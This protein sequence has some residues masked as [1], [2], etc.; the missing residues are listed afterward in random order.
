[1]TL[2]V[3]LINRDQAVQVSDRRL[4]YTD[5]REPDE[6]SDKAI[7]FVS[8]SARLAVGYSSLAKSRRFETH[9]WLVEIL[10]DGGDGALQQSAA[11]LGCELRG[12]HFG[13]LEFDRVIL[14]AIRTRSAVAS[15]FRDGTRGNAGTT[16]EVP[17]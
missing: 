17:Q 10:S 4:T 16:W 9:L 5:G 8:P 2:I 3:Q 13:H 1:M 14:E 15:R 11:N 7:I 6:E 12:A